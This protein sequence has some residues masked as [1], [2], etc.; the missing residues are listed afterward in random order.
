MTG[1]AKF[2]DKSEEKAR[3]KLQDNRASPAAP[4]AIFP[5][6]AAQS[7][8][9]YGHHNDIDTKDVGYS[10][11]KADAAKADQNEKIAADQAKAQAER[12]AADLQVQ[13][14][15][16]KAQ[17]DALARKGRRASILTSASGAPGDQLG[18]SS[19]PSTTLFGA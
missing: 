8:E 6:L 9:M 10:Q 12:E 4:V 18:S 13:Q 15:R 16:E 19:S 1:A 7:K 3:Q 5:A 2:V 11:G 17:K 14:A